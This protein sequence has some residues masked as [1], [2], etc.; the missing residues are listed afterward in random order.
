MLLL[1]IA[2]LDNLANF[3]KQESKWTL[4]FYVRLF[5]FIS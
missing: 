3:G 1:L 4:L 5:V 2:L